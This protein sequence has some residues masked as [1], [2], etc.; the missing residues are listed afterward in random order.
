M[1]R[2]LDA[3]EAEKTNVVTDNGIPAVEV[4]VNGDAMPEEDK[5]NSELQN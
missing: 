2:L 5:E 4:G 3:E 1:F